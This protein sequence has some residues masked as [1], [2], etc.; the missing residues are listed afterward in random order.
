MARKEGSKV[1][2]CPN[3]TKGKKQCA[4]TL[5]VMPGQWKVC[6]SCGYKFR[7]TKTL[8]EAQK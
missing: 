1:I 6:G 4:A 2:K 5:V 3:P 7:A 8:I